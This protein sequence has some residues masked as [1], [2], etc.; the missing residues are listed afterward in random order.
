MQ[1]QYHLLS[2]MP[3]GKELDHLEQQEIIKKVDSSKC[4]GCTNCGCS[5]EEWKILIV[6]RLQGE[7]DQYPLPKPEDLFATQANC[8]LWICHNP[9]CSS[10]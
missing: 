1:P 8:T 3:L 9:S 6:C 5:K 7:V 10:N 4:M 2:K